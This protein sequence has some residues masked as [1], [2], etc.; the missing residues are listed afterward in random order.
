MNV[1]TLTEHFDSDHSA[2][3]G[4]FASSKGA[5]ADALA[6]ADEEIDRVVVRSIGTQETVLK[7][8]ENPEFFGSVWVIQEVEVEA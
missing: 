6:Q 5:A 2:Q 1:W 4:I 3:R 8:K 7:E